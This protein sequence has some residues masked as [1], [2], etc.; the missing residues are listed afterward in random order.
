MKSLPEQSPAQLVARAKRLISVSAK[1][2]GTCDAVAE[3]KFDHDLVRRLWHYCPEEKWN[4]FKNVDV[5]NKIVIMMVTT[6][7]RLLKS[8]IVFAGKALT[9][10]GR[11]TYKLKKLR[12]RRGWR[13]VDSYHAERE[14][15]VGR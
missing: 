8:P 4:D 5:K 6:H 3:H 12:S 10:Y 7:N 2:A 15:A 13:L 1:I 14:L 11:W 9:Y